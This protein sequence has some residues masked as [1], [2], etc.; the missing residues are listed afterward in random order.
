MSNDR[1]SEHDVAGRRPRRFTRW[2]SSDEG[3][4]LSALVE[5]FGSPYACG[6]TLAQP[7]WGAM[8]RE[9]VLGPNVLADITAPSAERALLLLTEHE[10]A[11]DITTDAGRNRAVEFLVRHARASSRQLKGYSRKELIQAFARLKAAALG[12]HWYWGSADWKQDDLDHDLDS[13]VEADVLRM[14]IRYRCEECLTVQWVSI[15]GI[16]AQVK[17]SGCGAGNHLGS[18]PVWRYQVNT[19]AADAIRRRGVIAVVQALY[20]VERAANV[21]SFA[22]LPC[23]VIYDGESNQ[24]FTDL[25]LVYFANRE[26]VIGEVKA[27]PTGFAEADLT[28][29]RDV[30]A[31]VRPNR[32]VLAAPEGEWPPAIEELFRRL[33]A[34]Q[35][36][37]G[38]VWELKKL[39]W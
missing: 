20:S 13:Y 33:A 11:V 35:E 7:F 12:D 9:L 3:Q 22:A 16:A 26:L 15:E 18:E 27:D 2:R 28:K 19:L 30:A 29:L 8:L 39:R 5:L 6:H 32:V 24:P 25:D 37:L 4:F 38:V 17:C 21:L 1:I 10:G 31:D 23:T 14:G 36:P 34:E